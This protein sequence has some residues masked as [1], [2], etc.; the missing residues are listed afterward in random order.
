MKRKFHTKRRLKLKDKGKRINVIR[1]TNFGI[2]HKLSVKYNSPLKVVTHF[3]FG[4]QSLKISNV[5]PKFSKLSM[6]S[7]RLAYPSNQTEFWTHACHVTFFYA[8]LSVLP[9]LQNVVV[10]P[11]GGWIENSENFVGANCK[12]LN[13]D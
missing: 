11:L 5:P 1:L 6:L 2:V 4:Y 12:F 13:I 8:N 9:S 10:L 3:K 7:F